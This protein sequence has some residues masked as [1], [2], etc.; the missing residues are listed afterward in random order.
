MKFI[1]NSVFP[2]ILQHVTVASSASDH[3]LF[4]ERLRYLGVYGRFAAR[5]SCR[6]RDK[7]DTVPFSVHWM[8]FD[9]RTATT[10]RRCLDRCVTAIGISAFVKN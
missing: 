1:F 3:P 4:S 2:V 10:M 9:P 7:T 6:F 8:G 5:Q